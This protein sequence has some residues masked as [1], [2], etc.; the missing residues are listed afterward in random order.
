[1]RRR[2]YTATGYRVGGRLAAFLLTLIALACC[3][4]ILLSSGAIH[5]IVD[6]INI[7]IAVVVPVEDKADPINVIE[8]TEPASVTIVIP[9]KPGVRTDNV[10]KL[11]VDKRFSV[12]SSENSTNANKISSESSTTSETKEPTTD[13][14]KAGAS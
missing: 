9:H 2:T 11:E 14:P 10:A 1:M 8:H 5:D 12:A 7:N 13:H 3:L 6:D 4:S